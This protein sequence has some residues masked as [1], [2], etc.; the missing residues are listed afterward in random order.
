MNDVATK[1]LVVD[2]EEVIR[3]TL[4]KKLSRLGYN[5]VSMEKAEDALYL[6]KN[7]E[8]VDLI[9][10]D[11]K[12][13]KMDGIELLRRINSQD[14]SIPVLIITGHG[15]VEDAI[16]A[17]RYGASDFIR[18]PFDI[19][20]VAASVRDILKRKKEKKLAESF[21]RYIEYEKGRISIPIDVSLIDNISYYL[22]KNLA[23]MGLFNRTTSENMALA[24]QE[25][26]SNAMFHGN[27]EI[28]S[29][30]RED[31]GLK[32]FNEEVEKRRVD[33]RFK[34]RVVNIN[35]ELTG[36]YAEYIIEDEG[37]GFDYTALPDP[38][39]PENFFRNSGRGLLI[40]RIHMDEVEWND[41]GNVLR[42]RKNR[43]EKPDNTN[44]G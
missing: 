28:S 21:A 14:E 8:R 44:G 43:I 17:L 18:K 34:N 38:R 40:I 10:T 29:S 24:L 36:E 32:A 20:D 37:P 22:T 27:L 31:G 15:N 1:I 6:L 39:D 41:R 35:Y 9:I 33:E 23:A 25:A 12:L 19:N 13:R 5:V 4:Q 26:I 7:G 3:Y 16:R 42:L 30:I 2:D 11:V